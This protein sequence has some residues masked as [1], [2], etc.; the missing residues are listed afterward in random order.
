[1]IRKTV[2]GPVSLLSTCRL[3]RKETLPIIDPL[4]RNLEQQ[5][6]RLVIDYPSLVA[7]YH[8][9]REPVAPMISP[10]SPP[11]RAFLMHTRTTVTGRYQLEIALVSGGRVLVLSN[12]IKTLV[13]LWREVQRTGISYL[14]SCEGALPSVTNCNGGPQSG[15]SAWRVCRQKEFAKK[16]LRVRQVAGRVMD[17]NA[18]A[19]LGQELGGL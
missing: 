6:I 17:G 5:P 18:W 16:P 11:C 14:V 1:M 3:V 4:L 13:L 12:V 9:L 7:T 15:I 10:V 8:P 2:P 19:V